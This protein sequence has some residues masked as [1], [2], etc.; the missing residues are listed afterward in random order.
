M[1]GTKEIPGWSSQNLVQAT[2]G[3]VYF[4]G[5][6]KDQSTGLPGASSPAALNHNIPKAVSLAAI[7]SVAGVLFTLA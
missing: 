6:N 4:G 5:G 1:A 7:A 2:Q 3:G